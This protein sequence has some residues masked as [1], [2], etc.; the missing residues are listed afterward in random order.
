MDFTTSV[1]LDP[2]D[3]KAFFNRGIAEYNLKMQADGCLDLKKAS[4]LGYQDADE[5]ISKVCK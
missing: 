5:Y 2:N 1:E 4:E 3:A